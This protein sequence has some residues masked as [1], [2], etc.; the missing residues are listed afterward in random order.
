MPGNSRQGVRVTNFIFIDF[1]SNYARANK[2]EF[3]AEAFAQGMLSKK[4]GKYTEQVMDSI[5]KHLAKNTQ[6]KIVADNKK[7]NDENVIIWEENFGGGYPIDEEAYNEFKEKQE[8]E[9]DK[10]VENQLSE[11]IENAKDIITKSD[12][13]LLKGL[14]KILDKD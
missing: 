5:D 14:E 3:V 11:I 2:Y 7:D 13:P 10:K 1:I 4:Y 8:K 6:L 9:T 12:L